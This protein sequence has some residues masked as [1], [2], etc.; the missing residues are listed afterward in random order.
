MSAASMAPARQTLLRQLWAPL[1]VLLV[2]PLFVTT[3][4]QAATEVY[5]DLR[6]EPA[7]DLQFD[8]V[9]LADGQRHKVLRFSNTVANYG[10]GRLEMV[11]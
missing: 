8:T 7:T 2:A 4:T 11:G 10:Q 5:P 1:L 9:T 3:R 6:T